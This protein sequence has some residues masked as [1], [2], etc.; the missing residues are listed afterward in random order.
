MAQEI[1]R[2]FLVNPQLFDTQNLECLSIQQ[3]YILNEKSRSI[4]IRIQNEEALLTIKTNKTPLVRN[5]YEY[6]IPLKDAQ[7]MI[8]QFEDKDCIQK[9]RYLV[10]HAAHLWEVDFFEG[11]NKGLVIAEIELSSEDEPFEKPSWITKEVTH[12]SKYLNAQLIIHPYS[13]W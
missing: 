1:E 9:K 12:E 6:Q 5:E 4:R 11:K 10:N 2:K 3:F 7:E 8:S 13:I